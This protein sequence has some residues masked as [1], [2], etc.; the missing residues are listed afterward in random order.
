MNFPE[1]WEQPRVWERIFVSVWLGA[2]HGFKRFC[3]V[4]ID[5]P[6]FYRT[7]YGFELKR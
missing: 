1:G 4:F 2:K 6:W 3:H 7:R 5:M